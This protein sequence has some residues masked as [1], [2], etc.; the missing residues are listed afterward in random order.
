MARLVECG[1]PQG[2]WDFFGSDEKTESNPVRTVSTAEIHHQAVSFCSRKGFLLIDSHIE[3]V[4]AY[5]DRY[6]EMLK[7]VDA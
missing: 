4:Q 3:C 2:P 1:I 7:T 5:K 6:K